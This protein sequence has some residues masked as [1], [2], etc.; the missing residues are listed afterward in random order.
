MILYLMPTE[1]SGHFIHLL[2]VEKDGFEVWFYN[3]FFMI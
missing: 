2:Q 1:M 3:F